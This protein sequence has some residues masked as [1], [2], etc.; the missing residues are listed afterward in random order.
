MKI[1][2][3]SLVLFALPCLAQEPPTPTFDV[4]SVKISGDDSRSKGLP[5]QVAHGTLTTH[6]LALR[7][8]L[9][10]AYQMMPAQ[11]QGPDWLNDVR[12]D[13]TAKSAGPAS[14]QQ[15]CLMLQKLLA[16]RMGVKIHKE[17]KEMAVYVMT[18]AQ[19]G[20][21][22]TATEREGLMAATQ[23]KNGAMSVNGISMFELAAWFAGK[24]GDRPIV[25]LTG[26]TGR[27]NVRIDMSRMQ[28]AN[29]GGGERE[30]KDRPGDPGDRAD[31]ISAFI[32]LMRDQL[33]LKLQGAKQ[34]VDVLVVDHAERTPTAN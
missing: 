26:L 20:P 7:A 19:G 2:L 21:K 30:R 8:G 12:L 16:D 1:T 27:Y 3:L 24:L 33:G 15:V 31:Q 17:K 6:G 22:F 4:A 10:H 34:P 25:D 5:F 18:V 13:I 14:E 28:A 29:P 9:M 32:E 23:E 11:I